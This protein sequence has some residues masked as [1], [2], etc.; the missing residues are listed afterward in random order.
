MNLTKRIEEMAKKVEQNKYING[1][2][3]N[4]RDTHY[5]EIETKE[6]K[7]NRY[8]NLEYIEVKNTKTFLNKTLIW[9][10]SRY[11]EWKKKDIVD[12][13]Y[14]ISKKEGSFIEEYEIGGF[15][16]NHRNRKCSYIIIKKDNEVRLVARGIV[17]KLV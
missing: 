7:I 3:T 10:S 14:N 8:M 17:Y 4:S 6:D 16:D 2:K 5:Y 1:V 15:V 9:S 11:N 13:I 12:F